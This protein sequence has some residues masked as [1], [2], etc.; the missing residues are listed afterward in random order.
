MCMPVYN[1][2]RYVAEAV[3]SILGQTFSDFEFLIIDDGSTDGTL[4]ILERYAARDPRVRLTSR[5]NK[6]VPATLKELVDQSRGEFIAR[7]DADDIALPERFKKQVD[8]LRSHPDCVV[9]GCRVWEIDA[10]G[11][12]VREFATLS[13]HEEIDAFHFQMRG[14]ALVHPSIMLRRA[15]HAG[16]RR[17]P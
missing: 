5:P 12:P 14:P 6:G 11:D 3:E 17:L 2:R 15:R 7:M 16:R 4:P 13:D 8:Y 10:D 9:V 1:C